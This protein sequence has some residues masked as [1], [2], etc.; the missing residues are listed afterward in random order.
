M[1]L[2]PTHISSPEVVKEARLAAAKV[3]STDAGRFFIDYL[4]A[5]YPP[6]QRRF[7]AGASP[8]EAAIR[9]GQSQITE[10]I[11]TMTR[12]ASEEEDRQD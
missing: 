10:L 2:N 6:S 11:Q 4:L 9:D 5:R 3:Y 12:H 1:S 7:Q 8:I